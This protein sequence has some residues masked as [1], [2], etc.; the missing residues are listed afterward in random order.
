[1]TQKRTK[2]IIKKKTGLFFGSFNPI[3]TG[4]L[5]I[6][7]YFI[8]FSDLHQIW[9]VIT[10]HNPLK[11]KE[12]LLEDHHR[13]NMVKIAIEDNPAFRACDIEFR[14]AKPSYTIHTLAHLRER[15]PEKAFCLI[16]GGDNLETLDKWKHYELLLE[17]NEI[18]V[19][20]RPDTNISRFESHPNVKVFDAPLM[21]I[22]SSFIRDALKRNKKMHYFLHEK[23]N[24]Y[25]EDMFLYK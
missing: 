9:F 17:E 6:A 4:H 18:Y 2:P 20:K 24:T 25:I 14:L 3:H 10:P 7:Q 21:K 13:L 16:M 19:Y 5:I 11:R 22:S 12:S 8:E 15:Y 1:M 23:V